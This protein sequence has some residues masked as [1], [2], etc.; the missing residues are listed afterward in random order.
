MDKRNWHR[1]ICRAFVIIGF[2][3]A[4]GLTVLSAGAYAED[5]IPVEC[6]LKVDG[7][8]ELAGN[9]DVFDESKAALT[10]NSVYADCKGQCIGCYL[11]ENDDEYCFDRAGRKF[12]R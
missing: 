6:Y 9:V 8:Y 11:D 3:C 1:R 4:A 10:C 12:E 2:L 5:S 7:D